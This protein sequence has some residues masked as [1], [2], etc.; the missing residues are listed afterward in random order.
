VATV[1]LST[2]AAVILDA[3]GNGTAQIGPAGMR[4]HWILAS[5]AVKTNQAPAAIVKEAQC[6]IYCGADASDPNFAGGTLSGSTGDTT[7]DV[8]GQVLDCGEYVWAVWTGGDAGAQGRVVV[9]GSRI[10]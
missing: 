4:E 10:V 2:S 5:L 8:A 3:S 9:T 7:S 6:K 1:S